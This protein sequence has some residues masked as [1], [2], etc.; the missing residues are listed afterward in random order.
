MKIGLMAGATQGADPTLPGIIK[1]AQHAEKDG[2]NSVWMAS[3]LSFDAMTALALAGTHTSS[4]ELGTAVVPVQPRHPTT[5]AQQALT[6]A[7]ASGGRFTLGIGL[8]HQVMIEQML[9]VEYGK[10]YSTMKEY[11]EVLNPF[12]RCESV[13]HSGDRYSINAGVSVPNAKPVPLIIAAMGP[14]MLKLAGEQADGTTTWV[15]GLKTLE[16]HIVPSI[17]S[18]AVAAGKSAPRIIAGLPVILTNDTEE[19]KASIAKSLEIYGKLPAYRAML[20]REGVSGPEDVALIGDEA[21]LREKIQ[22]LRDIGVTDFNAAIEGYKDGVYERTW[23][24]L[25]SE[26]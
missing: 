2:F 15:T 8:S 17:N 10:P 21:E 24:F 4:I 3:V 7:V 9:G 20:D 19:A 23:A 14:K 1:T 12:L 25:K 6:T 5:M 11:L 22:R 26:L 16:N 13:S 18:A